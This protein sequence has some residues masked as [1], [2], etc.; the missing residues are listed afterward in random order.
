SFVDFKVKFIDVVVKNF[1]VGWIWLVKNVDGS[2][3]IVFISNVGI[4][5]IIDVKLL[6]I[7]DVW[8]YVYYIDYCNVCLSYLDYFWVLVNWK[9]VVVN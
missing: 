1:G 2:L 9:F 4:L 3:V 5:L 6:L 7:V 8:E